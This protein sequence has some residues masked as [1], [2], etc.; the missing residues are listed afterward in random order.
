MFQL[1]IFGKKTRKLSKNDKFVTNKTK[2]CLFRYSFVFFYEIKTK[3]SDSSFYFS[4]YPFRNL[5]EQ[6]KIKMVQHQKKMKK[7]HRGKC[8]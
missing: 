1:K 8:H 5:S 3:H 2:T 6:K 4:C 7:P